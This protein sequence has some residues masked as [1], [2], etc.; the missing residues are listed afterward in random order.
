[1]KELTAASSL[2]SFLVSVPW[3]PCPPCPVSSTTHHS[4]T[5][6]RA[7]IDCCCCCRAMIE[8]EENEWWVPTL[9]WPVRFQEPNAWCVALGRRCFWIDRTQRC[10]SLGNG[11]DLRYCRGEN[12][13]AQSMPGAVGLRWQVV[14]WTQKIA[15]RGTTKHGALSSVEHGQTTDSPQYVSWKTPWRQRCVFFC[16]LCWRL[17]LEMNQGVL[18][19][20]ERNSG[21]QSSLKLKLLSVAE[22]PTQRSER[23][24]LR[25]QRPFSYTE[26]VCWS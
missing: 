22:D 9:S 20:M 3:N 12:K 17:W 25:A 10:H 13:G 15:W 5:D 16:S 7:S 23:W 18:H 6:R 24:I 21:W 2:C 1:M 26:K 11:M 8:R 19:N 14:W 4:L